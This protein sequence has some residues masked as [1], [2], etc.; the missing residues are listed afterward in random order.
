MVIPSFIFLF[1]Y[2]IILMKRKKILKVFCALFTF[3]SKRKRHPYAE[4]LL[5]FL[6]LLLVF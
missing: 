2:Y 4:C 5:I 3:S 6:I 1:E